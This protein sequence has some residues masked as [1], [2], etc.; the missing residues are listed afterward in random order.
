MEGQ[1]L[2]YASAIAALVVASCFLYLAP[3]VPQIVIDGVMTGKAEDAS[4]FTHWAVEVLGGEAF[5]RRNLWLPTVLIVAVTAIAGAFTY[6][7][8]RL[9]ASACERIIQRVRERVYDHLQ[10]L[11]CRFFDR[12]ET[13][14][15]I[16]R[17]T[18][19]VETLRTFLNTHVVEIGR[20]LIMMLVPIPLMLLIDVRM[21]I[22]SVLLL[23]IIVGFSALFFLRVK[24][25]FRLA[26]EAEA[27]MT[28][29][30][31]ENLAGIRV[32]RAFARQDHEEARFDLRNSEH[33]TCDYRLYRLMAW[34]WSTSDL[35]CMTQKALVIGAGAYWI[36]VGTL[37]V[38]AYFY[39]ITAVTMF[40]WP[41]RQMGRI[42][43]DLGK[44]QVALSRLD[45]ILHEPRESVP[46]EDEVVP[47]QPLAGEITF[48]NV[49]FSHGEHS[50]VLKDISFRVPAGSSLAILGPSGSGKSTIVNLLLRLYD[51][52][53]GS[54]QLDGFELRD[55]D[56][57]FARSQMSV[58]MQE[59]FLYSK[60]LR[61]NLRLARPSAHEEEI[62]E[63]T[64]IAAVHESIA[65]F[66]RG[67]DTL[68]G[69]RGVTLSGGQRQRVAIAR[70]LLQDPA[71]LILD[72]ALSAVD[73]GTESMIL[74]A[75][76]ERAG[77]HSTILIAHRVSTVMHADQIIVLDHGRIV[78]QGAHAE[79][80]NDAGLY[81]RLWNAQ[82][83]AAAECEQSLDGDS[84]EPLADR[85]MP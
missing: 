22:L 6:L 8:S 35:L 52:E 72:D 37:Q 82:H 30:I 10:H 9:S 14:D 11:P 79:L 34:Y 76:R 7:R 46:A 59:P 15:L 5:L 84:R 17:S 25:A 78:Q 12:A 50:P 66:A 69:E 13:G 77:R 64:T 40:I 20:A 74:D 23:P 49:S 38:G 85:T 29:R 36:A 41:M 70:A 43:T 56:R 42:L 54:I 67:Y 26:D 32:V 18:S 44:A 58:V 73:T 27:S 3:L 61:E 31:Q 68:V 16:Q 2:R 33:R 71:V 60:T 39:F 47:G 65:E 28:A 1:R 63:A 80:M 83:E 21:T 55:L 48:E 62:Y 4:A 57:K 81:R 75:L 53:A 24:K 45:E 51:Y 19:D